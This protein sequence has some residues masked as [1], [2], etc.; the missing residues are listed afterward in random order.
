MEAERFPK[1]QKRQ[2]DI[3]SFEN[4]VDLIITLDIPLELNSSVQ[5]GGYHQT[6]ARNVGDAKPISEL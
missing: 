1:V 2:P 6:T 4:V 3:Q 5:V